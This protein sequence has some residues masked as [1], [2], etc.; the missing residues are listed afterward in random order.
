MSPEEIA[1]NRITLERAIRKMPNDYQRL[2]VILYLMGVSQVEIAH[3][4]NVSR[5][6]IGLYIAEFKK[7]NGIYWSSN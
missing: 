1:L 3:V 4:Y 2:A 5:Q 7:R 6:A